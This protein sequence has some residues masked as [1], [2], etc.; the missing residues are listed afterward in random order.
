MTGL[1]SVWYRPTIQMMI[2]LYLYSAHLYYNKFQLIGKI[3]NFIIIFALS[4]TLNLNNFHKIFFFGWSAT[5]I[6]TYYFYSTLQENFVLIKFYLNYNL[7]FSQNCTVKVF[8]LNVLW[9]VLDFKNF[10]SRWTAT[11]FFLWF[12]LSVKSVI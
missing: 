9:F 2:I 5:F 6:K 12:V 1:T 4:K 8:F 10:N 7:M 3:F 11:Y